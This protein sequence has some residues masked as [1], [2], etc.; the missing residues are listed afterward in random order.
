MPT[1]I[2][3]SANSGSHSVNPRIPGVAIL[4]DME[5]NAIG[6]PEAAR[7][8]GLESLAGVMRIPPRLG[9]VPSCLPSCPRGWHTYRIQRRIASSSV[10]MGHQYYIFLIA[11][12][13]VC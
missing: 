12:R 1:D 9:R 8:L 3:T 2:T 6:F 4:I 7:R 11:M 10:V 5:A 13:V